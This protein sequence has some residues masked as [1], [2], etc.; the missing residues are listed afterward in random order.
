[1]S[2]RTNSP[3]VIRGQE[4]LKRSFRGAQAGGGPHAEQHSQLNHLEIYLAVF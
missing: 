2:Q 1:M 4:L 3:L